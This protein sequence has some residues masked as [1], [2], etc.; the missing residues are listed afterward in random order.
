M[1]EQEILLEVNDL[2]IVFKN[3]KE[4]QEVVHSIS[5]SIGK[6]EPH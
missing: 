1:Q 5:F 2:K 3:Q 4:W 6:N